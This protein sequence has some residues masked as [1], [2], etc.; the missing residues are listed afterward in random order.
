MRALRFEAARIPVHLVAVSF[1]AEDGLC[2]PLPA[3]NCERCRSS[4]PS[5]KRDSYAKV[6]TRKLGWL[7][8][9]DLE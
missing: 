3:I 2:D 1:A 7:L 5:Q 8:E 9:S 6:G 4:E